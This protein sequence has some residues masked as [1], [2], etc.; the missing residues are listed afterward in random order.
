MGRHASSSAL[1]GSIETGASWVAAVAALAV[2]SVAFGAP[3]VTVVALKPMA[4]DMGGERS[5]PA[6]AYSL[7][8]LGTAFGGMV[9]GRIADRIG[10]RWTAVF[11]GL[12][13]GI[14]LV[15]TSRGGAWTLY[16]SYGL[17][18]GVFGLGGINAPVYVYVSRWFDRRR[19]TALA[20][21]SSGSYVAGALW[22]PLFAP[23]IEDWGWRTTMLAFA[24]VE[25]VL[26]VPVAA[27]FLKPPPT[28]NDAAAA[29]T[30][31]KPGMTALGLSPAWAQTLLSAASF[32]CCV[33]MAMPQGHLVAFCSD[34]GITPTI[35]ATMLSVLLGT[36][37]FSRQFWGYVSDR[38]GG[39]N[40][41]LASSA[42]QAAAI[43]AL[44]VT[45]DEVGLFTVAAAFG[46]GFSGL[47]P[48]YVLAIRELFPVREA[49]WRVPTLMLCSG[50]G[51][52]FGGWLAGALY[53]HFGFYEAAFAAGLLANIANLVI[54]GFLATRGRRRSSPRAMVY[55]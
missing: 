54:V 28:A 41:V 9:M 34:L 15:L 32:L 11:G 26:V 52:A 18:I 6:M 50:S 10:V 19:G 43:A 13:I 20:L 23:L 48:A 36:A 55:P 30:G 51:M 22:P 42:C 49:P 4:A 1:P 5:V 31:P 24:A 27:V 14:G 17:L 37:F 47:I 25:V 2:M 53:D 40:T 38:I 33:P 29:A 21:I 44:L 7:A 8:W 12:M 39:I 45:Q 46:F 35:G 3:Y 16:L